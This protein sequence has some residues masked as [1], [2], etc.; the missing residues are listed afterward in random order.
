MW[1][2]TRCECRQCCSH[3]KLICLLHLQGQPWR[4]MYHAPLKCWE[5]CPYTHCLISPRAEYKMPP[6]GSSLNIGGR[7]SETSIALPISIWCKNSKLN[8][9]YQNWALMKARILWFKQT[10]IQIV[11]VYDYLVIFLRFIC[12][13]GFV[14][15]KVP[16][17]KVNTHEQTSV[18]RQNSCNIKSLHLQCNTEFTYYYIKIP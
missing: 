11:V 1:V 15:A 16:Q 13:T 18:Y 3:F 4:W 6:T 9:H 10:S 12:R 7:T 5:H 17:E 8:H 14:G 2:L